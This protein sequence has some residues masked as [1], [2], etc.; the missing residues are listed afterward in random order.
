MSKIALASRLGDCAPSQSCMQYLSIAISNGNQWSRISY[1]FNWVKCRSWLPLAP[2]TPQ[3]TRIPIKCSN[4]HWRYFRTRHAAL[5][6]SILTLHQSMLQEALHQKEEMKIILHCLRLKFPFD[7]NSNYSIF[8]F[9]GN[10]KN[11]EKTT[12]IFWMNK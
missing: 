12:F 7:R 6:I 1:V 4:R 10:D 11:D 5:K 3:S 8:V 2:S 9:F